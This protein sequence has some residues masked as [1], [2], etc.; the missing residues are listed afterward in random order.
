MSMYSCRGKDAC[1]DYSLSCSSG[2]PCIIRCRGEGAC[3]S[4]VLF[5]LYA[6]DVTVIC[7]EK[8]SCQGETDIYCGSGTCYVECSGSSACS[9]A[10]IYS[11]AA[12][13]FLCNGCNA[14]SYVSPPY[15]KRPTAIPTVSPTSNPSIS[16]SSNPSLIPTRSPTNAPTLDPTAAPTISPTI[17]TVSPTDSPSI[18]PT[19][20]PTAFPSISPTAVPTL[21]PTSIPTRIPTI[22]PSESPTIAPSVRIVVQPDSKITSSIISETNIT[23]KVDDKGQ[24]SE[25]TIG[26]YLNGKVDPSWNSDAENT[27]ATSL[28]AYG[29]TSIIIVLSIIAFVL[30]FVGSYIIYKR[31]IVKLCNKATST[32]SNLSIVNGNVQNSGIKHDKTNDSMDIMNDPII[33]LVEYL[34]DP[35]VSMGHSIDIQNNFFI[36]HLELAHIARHIEDEKDIHEHGHEDENRNEGQIKSLQSVKA[37]VKMRHGESF[38]IDSSV[39][40][41]AIILKTPQ[42]GDIHNES[43]DEHKSGSIEDMYGS[44]EDI[45]DLDREKVRTPTL[46]D[47]NTEDQK[48]IEIVESENENET[49]DRDGQ[50]LEIESEFDD[51]TKKNIG[52]SECENEDETEKEDKDGQELEIE[53]ECDV[54]IT[55]NASISLPALRT[56]RQWM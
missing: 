35:R 53:S 29:S 47:G 16:P 43:D 45:M 2:Y 21:E 40:S 33:G 31:K 15:T 37:R 50:E 55:P 25:P 49:A 56:K 14:A 28:K 10:N 30:V 34:R 11:G 4:S 26:T 17:I 8:D 42:Q 23:S 5:A 24:V 9:D 27:N 20:D 46:T 48:E 44:G 39:N 41:I 1:K 12:D 54:K 13:G 51:N 7:E 32:N 52:I 3:T 6:T 36:K 18:E 22:T 38:T 19:L